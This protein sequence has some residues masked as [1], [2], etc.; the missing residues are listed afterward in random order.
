MRRL[1]PL[2]AYGAAVLL[3]LLFAA[4]DLAA[5]RL[6]GTLELDAANAQTEG[7]LVEAPGQYVS[8][9]TDPKLIFENV[10]QGLPLRYVRL[11]A[12]FFTPPGE[13]DLFYTSAPGQG[14]SPGKRAIAAPQADGSWLYTLPPF[15]QVHSLRIDL[16]TQGHIGTAVAGITLNPRLPA[17]HFFAPTGRTVLG[18]LAWPAL[19]LCAIYSILEWAAIARKWA[20]CIVC[21]KF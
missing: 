19:A 1:L 12:S 14:F 18:L 13:L 9:N 15:T 8:E 6:S 16:G 5:N 21:P 2:M 4:L 3:W 10:A 7:L 17:G 20:T 11:S